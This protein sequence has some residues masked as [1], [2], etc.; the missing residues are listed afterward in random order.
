MKCIILFGAPGSGKGTQ[1]DLIKAH[2]G[3][4]HISTGNCFREAMQNETELGKKARA[5]IDEGRLV[6]DALTSEMLL[7]RLRRADCKGG[8][9]LDGYPRTR[10]Q[11]ET[12]QT[13]LGTNG[14]AS[15]RV[16]DIEVPTNELV[17]RLSGRLTCATCGSV[18][19][20]SSFANEPYLCKKDGSLL[21]RRPDDR[22]EAVLERLR[23]FEDQTLALKHYFDA[24][25]VLAK[26]DGVGSP[27]VIFE[28]V[29]QAIN[30][31]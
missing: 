31:I 15:V 16:V 2:Y 25:G 24:K 20:Q 30:P 7:E 5:F 21:Q 8:F 6:P 10:N 23:V 29:K 3:L 9:I 11:A 22:E 28:R 18:Y 17:K 4:V 12:L 13:F 1:A 19:H 27:M 14:L 26:V